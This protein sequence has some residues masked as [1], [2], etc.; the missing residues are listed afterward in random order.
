MQEQQRDMTGKLK[1]KIAVITG[2]ARGQG[3]ATARIFAAEGAR[4]VIADVLEDEGKSLAREIGAAALFHR[5]DVS[6]DKS[7]NEMLSSVA[8][9]WEAP[10]ILINNAGILHQSTILELK[11][12]DFERVLR[13]NLIGAWLGIKSVAPGM[14]A[15]GKGAVVNIC[16][17]AAISGINGATAYSASKW[18]LR[19][20]TKTA[21]ME[22]GFKGIRVNAVFPGAIN[23]VMN[24][25]NEAQAPAA[26]KKYTDRPIQ[27][28]GTPDEVGRVSL[29]L[30]SDDSSYLCGA[31]LIVDGGVTV[32]TYRSFMP[33]APD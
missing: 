24:S 33:G 2:G 25:S 3:A 18:A 14:I 4:I 22:L 12:E 20:L 32:G 16:S 28:A 11:Q 1:D 30:V 8:A 15:K 31:E 10:D 17:T 5:L 23:T 9:K 19:G 7:W 26:G 29:F 6:N 27:R 21:A 13:V